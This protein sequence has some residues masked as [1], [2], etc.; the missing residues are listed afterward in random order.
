M[1]TI[2]NELPVHRSFAPIK[3]PT[4]AEIKERFLGK[5]TFG[6]VAYQLDPLNLSR[7]PIKGEI[8]MLSCFD[9]NIQIDM[10]D[11][12]NFT[13]KRTN[14]SPIT[15]DVEYLVISPKY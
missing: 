10:M 6:D 11:S 13:I 5:V 8:L 4:T 2:I 14:G 1:S 12:R 7:D 9:S 15:V 3:I